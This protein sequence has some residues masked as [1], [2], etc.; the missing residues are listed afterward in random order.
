MATKTLTEILR[1]HDLQA[2]ESLC[3]RLRKYNAVV[4]QARTEG[5]DLGELEEMLAEI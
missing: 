5:V 3:I 4:Q 2:L 1:T